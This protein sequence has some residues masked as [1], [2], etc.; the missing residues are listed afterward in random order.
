[1]LRFIVASVVAGAAG[2]VIAAP[3][4][5]RARALVADLSNP[6]A[7]VR[8]A[9][10][11][12]LR[13]RPD[14]LPWLRRA[15]RSA[16]RDVARR[17]VEL[18][19]PHEKTRQEV[20]AKAIDACI[21]EGRIDLLTEWHQYWRPRAEADL[22][23]VGLR[24]AKAGHDLLSQTCPKEVWDEA[25][26]RL[27]RHAGLDT[28]SHDGPCPAGR[29]EPFN[30]SWFIRTDRLDGRAHA[31]SR[32][33]FASVGGPARLSRSY[34]QYLVLGPVQASGIDTAFVA[35]DGD[36][37]HEMS[38]FGVPLGTRTLLGVVVC[39]GNVTADEVRASV[40]LVD[41]D[42]DLTMASELSDSLIRASGE[43]R[44]PKFALRNENCKIEAHAKD[45]TAP[46]KFFEL[47]DVG[48][49]VVDDEEGMVVAEVKP[50]TPFG[51]SGLK[52][53]DVIQAIDDAAPGHSSEFRRSVRRALVRQGDCLLTVARGRE[54]LDIP[55]YFPPPK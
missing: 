28:R 20:V 3:Q 35:C 38:E 30:G 32:I 49:S 10:A 31:A 53:G 43:I 51:N 44:L 4:P 8:D 1:M 41:G 11:E 5:E 17:A 36:V 54:K 46:Y 25:A 27:D 13:T 33:R 12:A 9:S 24:A 29:F 23:P 42:I 2:G 14:A 45:A 22:W 47:A 15:A 6:D 50:G 52:K 39:R 7:K 26:K 48:L 55:V 16:D 40:L 21:R 34:G 18:L 37:W 19:A